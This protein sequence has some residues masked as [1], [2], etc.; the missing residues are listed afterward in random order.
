MSSLADLPDIVGFFS[1][2]RSDDKDDALSALR[3]RI[4]DEL[5]GQLGRRPRLWQDTV[6]IPFGTQWLDQIKAA[7]AESVFFIPIVSPIALNSDY[8]RME[9]EAFLAR[10]R[11]LGRGD[12]V[13]PILYIP[14]SGRLNGAQEAVMKIFK[15][16]QCA[17]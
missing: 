2:A 5:H 6:A 7:I 13:F 1:Y 10:E 4:C 14:V 15:A 3:Q 8:C 11:E 12:L 9:F 17:D 16:R